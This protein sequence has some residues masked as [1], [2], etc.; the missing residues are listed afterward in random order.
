[1]AVHDRSSCPINLAIEL[2]GDRWTLLI[3]RDV[4]F[5]DRRHFR[6]LLRE[7]E[8]N[9][10]SSILADRLDRLVAA[11]VLTREGVATH[12]QKTVYSLTEKGVD[13]VP[14][15]ATI[16]QWGADHCAADPAKAA[17]ARELEYRRPESWSGLMSELRARHSVVAGQVAGEP[18]R[19]P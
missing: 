17:A 7:S 14:V 13:L 5:T 6:E 2:F 19:R 9:I 10:T 16:G 15:L 18:R 8:E 3:L 1:M 4:I 12:K 11:G